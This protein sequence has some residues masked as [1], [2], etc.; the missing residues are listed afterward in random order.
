MARVGIVST[1]PNEQEKI[2]ALFSS[3]HIETT[4]VFQETQLETLSGLILNISTENRLT[5]TID[6][7]L[8]LKHFPTMFVWVFAPEVENNEQTIY[9]KLGVNGVFSSFTDKN[10]P[11]VTYE[12]KNTIERLSGVPEKDSADLLQ[13]QDQSI[14]INGIKE[15]LTNKEFRLFQRLNEQ[16]ENT[17]GYEELFLTLWP[18]KSLDEYKEKDIITIANIVFRLRNKLRNSNQFVIKTTR[19]KGYRLHKKEE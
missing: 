5:D 6:W 10:L 8:Q 2:E 3:V 15:E 16:I 12:I 4:P 1:D 7:L 18:N 11:K 14:L 9:Y 13:E 17:V 19:G